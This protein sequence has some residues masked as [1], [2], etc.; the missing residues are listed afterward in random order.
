M[1]FIKVP[2]LA[3]SEIL[4]IS[5]KTVSKYLKN[6]LEFI[7]ERYLNKLKTIG[8]PVIIVEIDETKF[9]RRK[10]YRG[11]RVDGIWVLGMVERTPKRRI[12]FIPVPDRKSDTLLKII[13]KYVHPE[14]LIYTDCWKGYICLKNEFAS[15][16]TVNH[17]IAFVDFINNVHTNTIEGNWAGI[18]QNLPV[19]YRTKDRIMIYLMRYMLKRISNDDCFKEFIKFLFS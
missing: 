5:S 17:S 10:Y 4:D 15:H 2:V 19:Q 8:G 3:I 1:W 14:S 11:H 7:E 18:K 16:K 6:A 12:V 9:G 13:K